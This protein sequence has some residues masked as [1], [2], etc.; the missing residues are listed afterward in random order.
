MAWRESFNHFMLPLAILL[1][2]LACVLLWFA[3]RQR[4]AAGLPGGRIIYTD[5][6]NW[7]A[8]EKPLYAADI[9]LTGKPDYL[10]KH[11]S[12]FIP[13][14][15]KSSHPGRAPYD[16]HIYQLAAYCILVEHSFGQ[17]PPYG[18]LHYSDGNRSSRT[19]AIDFTPSLEAAVLD[20]IAEI[21][22]ISLRKGIDRSHDL[23][24]RCSRCGFRH[25]CD[26]QL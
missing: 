21:Q 11:G 1:A 24:A 12:S 22:S 9:G 15:V 7:G 10:V 26:Q 17:R 20:S 23:P 18:I 14:E 8:V 25:V 13:V 2:L 19:Y 3:A 16:S 4:K 5:T 6:T